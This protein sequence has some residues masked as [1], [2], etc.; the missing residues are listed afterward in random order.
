MKRVIKFPYV[1]QRKLNTC[2]PAVTEMMLKFFGVKL[3]QEKLEKLERTTKDG[4]G[5]K[6]LIRVARKHGLYCFVQENSNLYLLKHF[7]SLGL[8]VVVNYI[9]PSSNDGHYSV[10]VGFDAK[11]LIMNDPWNGKNFRIKYSDFQERWFDI[12]KGNKYKNWLL[13]LS[14]RKF[15][16]GRQ[17]SPLE[18]KVK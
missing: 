11:N 8:P 6:G 5:H 9:E 4:T 7:I 13:V 1:K 15:S 16:I 14:K 18:K 3:T 12:H 17:Y 10:V 2:G